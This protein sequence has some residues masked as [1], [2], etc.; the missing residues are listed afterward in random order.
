MRNLDEAAYTKAAEN[1]WASFLGSRFDNAL[2]VYDR[3]SQRAARTRIADIELATIH[4]T[5]VLANQRRNATTAAAG[6]PAELLA[7]IFSAAAQL[8]TPLRTH[9]NEEEEEEGDGVEE[10][11]PY[12]LGWLLVTHVCRSWR[13]A[14]I[15]SPNLWNK[16]ECLGIPPQLTIDVLLR[17]KRLPLELVIRA[18]L[19]Q[20]PED[21]RNSVSVISGWLCGPSLLR[22][23]KVILDILTP[24][25]MGSVYFLRTA[26]PILEELVIIL[27][28]DTWLPDNILSLNELSLFPTMG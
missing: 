8:W 24:V 28:R 20:S 25:L 11:P 9:E 13:K 5:L 15:S 4:K 17:S 23:R 19:S 12:D 18:N 26:A 27:D 2:S 14:A 16:L 21:Y 7:M 22:T 3:T 10:S 6:L 1:S